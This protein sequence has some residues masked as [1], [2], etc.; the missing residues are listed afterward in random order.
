MEVD[1]A[2]FAL[3][4]ALEAGDEFLS[5]GFAGFGPEEAGGDAAVFFDGEGE[6]EEELDVF[7]DV[8]CGVIEG[9]GAGV[10]D[11]DDF[12]LG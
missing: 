1:E 6:G 4:E 12:W 11:G 9:G 10:P 5:E 2:G 8:G 7:L 3:V